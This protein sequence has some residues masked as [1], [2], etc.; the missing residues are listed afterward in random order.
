MR[1]GRD[2][3][4][5]VRGSS[6]RARCR[7]QQ[8]GR[9][10]RQHGNA[11]TRVLGRPRPYDRILGGDQIRN[12]IQAQLE[13]KDQV[14][15]I[16]DNEAGKWAYRAK[17][18]YDPEKYADDDIFGF[19]NAQAAKESDADLDAGARRPANARKQKVRSTS[20]VLP[21]LWLGRSRLS[22]IR[23]SFLSAAPGRRRIARACSQPRCTRPGTSMHSA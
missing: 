21:W 18:V 1:G 9:E 20:A 7:Q 3:K 23:V 5:S 15:R 10:P 6:H 13:N 12:P 4:V 19:M 2:G 8:S 17:D 22:R 14:N 11:A 16:F